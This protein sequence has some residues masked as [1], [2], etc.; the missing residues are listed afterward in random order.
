LPERE[1]DCG[2]FL[3]LSVIFTL[4]LFDPFVVGVKVTL[5]AQ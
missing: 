2:L 1:I 4:P 3:A 5:I